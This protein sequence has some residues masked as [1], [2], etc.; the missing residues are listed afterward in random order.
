MKR[1]RRY[2]LTLLVF[3][4]ALSG[5]GGDMADLHRYVA[6]IKARAP[7]KIAPLPQIKPYDTYTYPANLRD[8]F[9]PTAAPVITGVGGGPRPDPTRIKE[10]L[11]AFPLDTLRLVGSLER[12]GEQWSLIKAPDGA[13]HRVRAGN[14]L[15]QNDGRIIHLTEQGIELAEL[16]EDGQG[17]WIE[18]QA[19]LTLGEDTTEGGKK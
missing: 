1:R 17:G 15:G 12:A 3:G 13:V 8:P 2:P 11:E 19:S 4:L 16:I 10:A 14:Y 7:G 6:E 5:C 18:R 9:T